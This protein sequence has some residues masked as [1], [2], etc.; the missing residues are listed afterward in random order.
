MYQHEEAE[1]QERALKGLAKR[2]ASVRARRE[3]FNQLLYHSRAAIAA[4]LARSPGA[5]SSA[6][7]GKGRVEEVEAAGQAVN[8]ANM[9]DLVHFIATGSR[10]RS[11]RRR[12]TQDASSTRFGVEEHV[13]SRT[14]I[15]HVHPFYAHEQVSSL[16]LW[17]W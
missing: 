6:S 16:L 17:G 14:G 5:S 4:A 11:R 3:A 8:E 7:G 15:T 12:V 13:D 10:H 2:I 1:A 9:A